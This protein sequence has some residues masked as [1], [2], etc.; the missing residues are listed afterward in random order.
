[1]GV[2]LGVG[3]GAKEVNGEISEEE[4]NGSIVGEIISG[5]IEVV[6]G[7]KKSNDEGMVNETETLGVGVTI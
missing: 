5:R 6:R 2:G 4:E 7:T 3:V 1:M